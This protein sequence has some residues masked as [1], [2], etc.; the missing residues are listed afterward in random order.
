MQMDILK[1]G[2]SKQYF[3]VLTMI[4]YLKEQK[5]YEGL[6][7]LQEKGRERSRYEASSIRICSKKKEIVYEQLRQIAEMYPPHKDI[8]IIDVEEL[9]I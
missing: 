2:K 3:V 8:T 4:S 9:D 6:L 7:L 5:K 1:A